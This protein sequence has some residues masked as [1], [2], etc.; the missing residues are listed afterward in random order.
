MSN[1]TTIHVGGV[2]EEIPV[3][4]GDTIL[5]FVRHEGGQEYHVLDEYGDATGHKWSG[6][7]DG[8]ADFI[9]LSFMFDQI[10]GAA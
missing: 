8:I 2:R 6:D 9:A 5:Y 7:I 3:T 10:D 1:N 4:R